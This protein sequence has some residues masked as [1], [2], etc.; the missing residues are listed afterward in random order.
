MLLTSDERTIDRAEVN[1]WARENGE[2]M[3]FPAQDVVFQAD[4]VLWSWA[5]T[6][7][8]ERRAPRRVGQ[9][10]GG[11]ARSATGDRAQCGDS[12]ARRAWGVT[13]APG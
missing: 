7:P 2:R 11:A 6:A 8:S 1:R 4:Q 5:E 9:G 3:G 10:L 13:A 12:C